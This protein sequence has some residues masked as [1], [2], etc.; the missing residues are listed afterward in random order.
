MTENNFF[1]EEDYLE[2]HGIKG[3]RWGIRRTPEQLGHYV[4]RKRR[5]LAKNI[6]KA[7]E[8][9]KSG[10]VKR[11]NKLN[12]RTE[13]LSKQIEKGENKKEE[14]K[15]RRDKQEAD[16]AKR[17]EDARQKLLK[18][19]TAEEILA[20]KSDYSRAEL[21]EAIQRIDTEIKLRDLTTQSEQKATQAKIMKFQQTRDMGEK[22]VDNFNTY[23]KMAK[24][25]N[26]VTGKDTLPVFTDKVE[27][28]KKEK[29]AAK[30][31]E[32]NKIVRSGDYETVMNNRQKLNDKEFKEAMDR[33]TN[34]NKTVRDVRKAEEE[35]RKYEEKE[36]TRRET[37]R[38]NRERAEEERIT[39]ETMANIFNQEYEEAARRRDEQREERRAQERIVELIAQRY[40]EAGQRRDEQREQR[41]R[42]AEFTRILREIQEEYNR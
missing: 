21:N 35:R 34:A 42:D 4:E 26:K 29:E 33:I 19:G 18:T 31:A 7:E 8:A 25:I 3:M 10:D 40:E 14:A 39:R 41:R 16:E 11:L 12:K 17:K 28:A 23:E 20:R 27:K 1:L 22:M 24:V 15:I 38:L 5:R 36:A 37:E 6:G 9:A 13:R 2:H 30:Q 32:I